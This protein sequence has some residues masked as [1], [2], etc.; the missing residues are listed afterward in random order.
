[1][2]SNQRLVKIYNTSVKNFEQ[3][4]F[5]KLENTQSKGGSCFENRN[6][7]E[8]AKDILSDDT[9]INWEVIINLKL[10]FR[11]IFPNGILPSG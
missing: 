9:R 8:I 11:K 5:V 7:E 3:N 2:G 10:I 1:M 4:E 6:L